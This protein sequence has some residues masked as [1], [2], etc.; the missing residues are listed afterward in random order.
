M[1]FSIRQCE[2]TPYAMRL[3]SGDR[4]GVITAFSSYVVFDLAASL[5]HHHR[6]Q[7]RST[8]LQLNGM[9]AAEVTCHAAPGLNPTVVFVDFSMFAIAGKMA[10]TRRMKQVL[11]LFF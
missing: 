2:R 5:H 3:A 1:L 9:H 11:T 10:L 6:A 8:V 7:S 4:L